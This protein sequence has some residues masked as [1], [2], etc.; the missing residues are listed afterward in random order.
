MVTF[1]GGYNAAKVVAEAMNLNIWWQEPQ[2][3]A[4]ARQ[5]GFLL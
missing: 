4:D 1:G 2:A 5:K 3:V